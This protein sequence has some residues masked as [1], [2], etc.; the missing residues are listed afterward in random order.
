MGDSK[1]FEPIIFQVV[2]PDCE[3]T[4]IA[5]TDVNKNLSP[6]KP[7]I[8]GEI[9]EDAPRIVTVTYECENGHSFSVNWPADVYERKFNPTT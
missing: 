7:T 1:K 6:G 8:G 5:E 9:V 4:K 2:C 3:S